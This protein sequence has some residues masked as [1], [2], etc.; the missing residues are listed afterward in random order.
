MI[1][2][3]GQDKAREIIFTPDFFSVIDADWSSIV[4]NNGSVKEGPGHVDA[5]DEIML[6]LLSVV[7]I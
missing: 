1:S 4:N 7:N 2:C 5:A 3:S 6:T